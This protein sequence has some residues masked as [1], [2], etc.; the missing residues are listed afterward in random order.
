MRKSHV[1]NNAR[2]VSAP[3]TH[4]P[5]VPVGENFAPSRFHVARNVRTMAASRVRKMRDYVSRGARQGFTSCD[6]AMRN[7]EHAL[8]ARNLLSC[9]SRNSILS[10]IKIYASATMIC[11]WGLRGAGWFHVFAN[12]RKTE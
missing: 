1:P 12:W 8:V 6:F 5:F 7:T 2:L 11:T 9:L 10:F 3:R 4:D